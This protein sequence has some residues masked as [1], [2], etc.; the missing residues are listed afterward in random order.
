MRKLLTLSHS[1]EV[2][3]Q[4]VTSKPPT[5]KGRTERINSVTLAE[6]DEQKLGL[7]GAAQLRD[8]PLELARALAGGLGTN[9]KYRLALTLEEL[10]D[11]QVDMFDQADADARAE[12]DVEGDDK[13]TLTHKGKSITTTP[14]KMTSALERVKRSHR[15]RGH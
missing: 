12:V 8:V 1:I 13:V 9:R 6:I 10:P 11:A 7:V 3:C 15:A 2:R 5:K 4:G 14:G